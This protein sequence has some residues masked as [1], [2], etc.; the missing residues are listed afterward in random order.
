MMKQFFVFELLN[1]PRPTNNEEREKKDRS[2]KDHPMFK[3][4]ERAIDLMKRDIAE[5]SC[6]VKLLENLRDTILEATGEA[7]EAKPPVAPPTPKPEAP[8]TP[9]TTKG[10][11]SPESEKPQEATNGT[12]SQKIDADEPDDL[13]LV[14]PRLKILEEGAAAFINLLK[15]APMIK[16]FKQLGDMY[17][18]VVNAYKINPEHNRI[19]RTARLEMALGNAI[20][21]LQT[22]KL[23]ARFGDLKE[24]R[25]IAED[26]MAKKSQV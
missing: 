16:R 24:A 22:S 7:E 9:Q 20:T 13:D 3:E 11:S 8:P 23:A 5:T 1:G 12:S 6:K 26:T 2:V 18:E 25:K 4:L 10:T 15:D 19:Q 17:Q 14:I 21:F